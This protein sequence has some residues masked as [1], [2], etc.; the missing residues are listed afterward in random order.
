[1]IKTF[2]R[3]DLIRF[4]YKETSKEED[5]RIRKALLV[6]DELMDEFKS[7]KKLIRKIEGLEDEPSD[8]TIQKILSYSKT[9]NLHSVK[10]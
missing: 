4:L 5:K 10:P 7:L 6:D 2:T 1:M 9:L 8:D 3:I